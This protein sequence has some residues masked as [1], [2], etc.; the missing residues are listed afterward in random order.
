M[1]TKL[2]STVV[3]ALAQLMI[4]SRVHAGGLV[5][6]WGDNI[7]GQTTLPAAANDVKAI[8]AGVRH[9]LALKDDGTVLAWG[10]DASGETDVPSGL[11]GVKAVATGNDFSAALKSDGTVVAW[12]FNGGG[13][14]EVPPGLSGVVAI[15]AGD[16]QTLAL[17]S[18]GRVAAWGFGYYYG[19]TNVP[20]GLSNVIAIAAGSFHNLALKADGTVIAW[21]AGTNY[22]SYPNYGQS[23]VPQNLSNV[24]AIAAGELHSV[25]L[26]SDGT[27]V[28]WG[29]NLNARTNVPPDLSNVVAIAAGLDHSL[30]LKADGTVVVWG[31]NYAGQTNVPA[32]LTNVSAIAGGGAISLALVSSGPVQMTQD[33]QPQS[34]ALPIGSNVTFSVAASGGASLNY[35]WFLDGRA[36]TNNSRINGAT[37][38]ALNISNLQ[39]SD[40]GAYAVVVSNAF[41]SV[42]S[43]SSTLTVISPPFVAGQFTTN[44]T[45]GAGTDITLTVPVQGTPPLSCY[46]NFNG[47]NLAG[48]TN[49]ALSLIN[50][51]P[52]ISGSYLL[53]VTNA[54][55]GMQAGFS[56]AVTNRPPYIV[57]QPASQSGYLGYSAAF[58]VSAKGS[59]PLSYQWRFAGADIPG[60][61]NATLTLTN[62][63]SAQAGYYHVAVSNAFGQVISAKALLTLDKANV[64]VWGN[65]APTNLSP[66]LTNLVAVAGGYAQIVGLKSDGTIK[67]WATPDHSSL[68]NVPPGAINVV[69]VTAGI[70][71]FVLKSD[72]T[73]VKWGGFPSPAPAGLSNVLAIAEKNNFALALK[74]NNTVMAWGIN[75]FGQTDIPLGLSNVVAIAAGAF[76]GLAARADGSVVA[77]GNNQNGQTN[78]PAGLTNVIAVAGG[79]YHSLAL[80][81]DGTVAIWGNY[82]PFL[83]AP[84][85]LSNIVAIAAGY[86]Q[87]LALKADGSLLSWSWGGG[88]P[89][90]SEL[91]NVFAVAAG[92]PPGI[93][94]FNVALTGDGSPHITIQPMSQSLAAGANV[95]LH[96]RAVGVQPMR[97][98][99]QWNGQNLPRAT[100]DDLTIAA[101]APGDYRMIATNALGSAIS[102]VAQV[103]IPFVAFNTNL[104]AAL[105]ATNLV[106]NTFSYNQK[107][108]PAYGSWF[109]ENQVTHDGTAAAQ[110]GAITNT[111]ES[112]L[113][114]TV[115]GPGTLAF[116]WKVSSEADY[117]FLKFYLDGANAA[118]ISGEA[119]WQRLT[120]TIPPGNHTL[121]WSYSK[122]ASVSS[123]QDAGWLDQVTFTPTLLITQQPQSQIAWMGSN[124]TLQAGAAW[125]GIAYIQWLKNGTNLPDAH[126]LLLTLTNLTRADSGTYALQVSN[127]GGSATSSNATLVVLV[128]QRLSAPKILPDGSFVFS[129]NDADGGLLQPEDL[130]GFEVQAST[131]LLDWVTVPEA[132][133]TTNGMLQL[134][135]PAAAG[136]PMRFYRIVQQQN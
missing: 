91:S 79:S 105:N 125:S 69:S 118:A 75:N 23:A 98:Q 68:T 107:Q 61:T 35:Q 15:A 87:N 115:T 49:T 82:P 99:W 101:G 71:N 78:V 80:K 51:Q 94:G 92:G 64:F 8:S 18:D 66:G 77:W 6:A 83:E 40:M 7:Y 96:A 136:L 123:G 122:D 124:V 95:Q 76:H 21:G 134:R 14:T 110:S 13:Q 22:G 127:A 120:L 42:I 109:A 111:E 130:A 131:N 67:V 56:L 34:Q 19:L 5:A 128:P 88:Q 28:A 103:G 81:A 27:V 30:A 41:G 86:N 133:T 46:W 47:V 54:Y 20:A 113:Q 90:P 108:S 121:R 37:G 100:N 53:L 39:M 73:I 132:L 3:L 74:S 17:K 116:W 63:T 38:P 126:S 45:V 59:L 106:W 33:L 10:N 119:D 104:D 4:F 12:G 135:D 112:T 16:G 31:Y 129:A 1:K 52:D 60:A 29:Y 11:S 114:T 102:R 117:D 84:A 9:V 72:G 25:A 85:G 32:G 2:R 26:K 48:Q 97:Y 58:S 50:V 70:D 93:S 43:S 65:N 57:N 44:V 36:I 89:L 62:L 55:G 24:V